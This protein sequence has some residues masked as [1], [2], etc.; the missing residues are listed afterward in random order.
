M[1]ISDTMSLPLRQKRVEPELSLT[2]RIFVINQSTF[3]SIADTY[4]VPILYLPTLVQN[5]YE[6]GACPWGR[7]RQIL[8]LSGD[9][10]GRPNSGFAGERSS[11]DARTDSQNA[12]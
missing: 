9:H 3:V 2:T 5:R 6:I 8:P 10:Y 4:F 7:F 11:S 1:D 12:L